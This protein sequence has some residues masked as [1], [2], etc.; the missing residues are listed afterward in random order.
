MRR[1][2][3]GDDLGFATYWQWLFVRRAWSLSNEK[4]CRA[5][6]LL[7]GT[8]RRASLLCGLRYVA[9]WPERLGMSA[10][11]NK[12]L[13]TLSKGN[14]QKIQW[15][16]TC[17]TSVLFIDFPINNTLVLL[18]YNRKQNIT[19]IERCAGEGCLLYQYG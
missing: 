19:E 7:C 3:R 10:Y 16:W 8:T 9:H 18:Y 11:V 14:Q 4:D 17:R 2:I 15:E 12:W 1:K 13:N 6:D 5:A